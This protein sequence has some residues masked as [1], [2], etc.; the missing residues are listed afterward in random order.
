MFDI[1]TA[2]KLPPLYLDPLKAG[3]HV[4]ERLHET[5]PAAFAAVAPTIV[6]IAPAASPRCPPT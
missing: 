1:L 2:S 5:D 3:Y 6:A 4:H